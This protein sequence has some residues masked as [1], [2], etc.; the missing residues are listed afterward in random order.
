MKKSVVVVAIL[1][2]IGIV[3]VSS[4]LFT[5]REGQQAL[6]LRFG[7]PRAIITE[8][9][10]KFK[11]PFIE[12]VIRYDRRLLNLDPPAEQ[13]IMGDQKRVVVDSFTRFRIDDPL[14][15]YQ[16]VRTE[17]FA[18]QRLREVVN[19]SLRRVLGTET[20]T[21]LLSNKRDAIMQNIKEQ[22]AVEA[23]RLGIAIG[24][25]RIRRADL[26]EETSQAIYDRMRSEREREAREFRA[27]GQEAAQAIR[28]DADRQRVQILAAAQKT[29][30]LTRGEGEAQ[31]NRV[32]AEAYGRDPEF[33]SLYRSLQA[34][35]ESFNGEN[36]SMLLS[37]DSE[38]FRFFG[39]LAPRPGDSRQADSAP[40]AAPAPVG[41]PEAV[42][43][44]VPADMP[45]AVAESVR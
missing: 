1:L 33:F 36:T 26:P 41:T 23:E 17:E 37:P 22:V 7:A 35:R 18:R 19:G 34:Y 8:P 12:D 24:D 5:V 44:P 42:A 13:V 39:G 16:A 43:A 9:G 29:A 30:H 11:A 15:F 38:F 6:V 45:E 40:A 25:V 32:Y 3:A 28:A 10:L 2:V 27:K 21:T 14:K 31:A 4:A 20:L